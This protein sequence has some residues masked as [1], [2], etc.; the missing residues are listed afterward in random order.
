MV[1]CGGN[2][3]TDGPERPEDLA[4]IVGDPAEPSFAVDL[5][6]RIVALYDLAGELLYHRYG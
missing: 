5:D 6:G 1:A 3:M 4:R 2:K